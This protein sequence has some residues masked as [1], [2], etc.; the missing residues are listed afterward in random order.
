MKRM[1]AVL[2]SIYFIVAA[3]RLHPCFYLSVVG[4]ILRV[5]GDGDVAAREAELAQLVL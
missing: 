4:F 1:L 5:A 2:E 3:F